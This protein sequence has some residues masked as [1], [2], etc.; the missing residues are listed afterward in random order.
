MNMFLQKLFGRKTTSRLEPKKPDDKVIHQWLDEGRKFVEEN[1]RHLYPDG[2]CWECGRG[3]FGILKELSL[4]LEMLNIKYLDEYGVSVT[5]KQ[6]KEKF[7]GLRVYFDVWTEPPWYYTAL[8]K[9]FD[10]LSKSLGSCVDYGFEYVEKIPKHYHHTLEMFSGDGDRKQKSNYVNVVRLENG[11]ELGISCVTHY[12]TLKRVPHR[13]RVLYFMS[14][15]F[16]KFGTDL[17]FSRLYVPSREAEVVR[18]Y[19]ENKAF[20]LT[21]K[22]EHKSY[23]ICEHCG[24]KLEENTRCSTRGWV[25]TL[26]KRCADGLGQEYRCNGKLYKN[27]VELQEVSNAEKN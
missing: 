27:G 12:P 13:H 22:A 16:G 15:I 2:F 5:V 9:F 10:K 1:C 26:C 4:E 8:G 14:W 23:L 6:V 3:W 25:K 7:G 11:N 17:D 20:E 18:E 21:S 24:E 19:V